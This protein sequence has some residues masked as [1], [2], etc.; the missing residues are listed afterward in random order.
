M[1]STSSALTF[2]TIL[3]LFLCGERTFSQELELEVENVI[4][5]SASDKPKG[6]GRFKE[7]YIDVKQGDTLS[8]DIK[9]KGG[10]N[11]GTLIELFPNDG[12][13]TDYRTRN[14]AF[15]QQWTSD[16]LPACRMRVRIV[17]YRPYGALSVY[18]EK[19]NPTDKP[20]E[21]NGEIEKM[22]VEQLVARHREL[23]AELQKIA[24]E[25]ARR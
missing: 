6:S 25:L 14:T 21:G 20:A 11:V 22:T 17:A 9:G 1:R 15:H 10:V 12:F 4:T 16:P 5:I 19:R 8:F 23:I 2:L 3:S 24:N 18:V 7:F 13:N